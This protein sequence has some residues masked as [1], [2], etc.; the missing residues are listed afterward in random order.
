MDI[1]V[2][3]CNHAEAADNKLYLTGGG[4]NISFV[5]PEPPHLVSVALG[6]V[7]HVPYTSTNQ[8]HRLRIALIDEDGHQVKPFQMEGGPD[9]AAIE[10]TIPFNIGRPPIISVGDEQT[11][12]F[13]I[14]FVNLPL[15][16]LGLYSLVFEIDGTEVKRQTWRVATAPQPQMPQVGSLGMPS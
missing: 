7:V 10:A 6:I 11:M 5:Q 3:L 9:L 12:A 14:N 16:H 15:A 1:D 4:I 13:A 8:G 2:V